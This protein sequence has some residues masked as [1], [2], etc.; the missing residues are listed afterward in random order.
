MNDERPRSADFVQSLERGLLVLRAF[1]ADHRELGLSEVA[2]IAGLPRAA[3]WGRV[4][5]G[6][7]RSMPPTLPE[8]EALDQMRFG[9]TGS[10]VAK[11]LSPPVT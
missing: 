10:G 1:D 2:R 5:S 3:A 4:R 8:P 9:S 11:P 6:L 7:W